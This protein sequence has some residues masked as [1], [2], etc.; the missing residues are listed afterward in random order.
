MKAS[1][2]PQLAFKNVFINSGVNCL[3]EKGL[4]I[5]RSLAPDSSLIGTQAPKAR[6]AWRMLKLFREISE[7][8]DFSK[9]KNRD[10]AL[11]VHPA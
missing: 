11:R 8:H 4:E 2:E 9:V 10:G 3:N 5:A 7:N 1:L 6:M